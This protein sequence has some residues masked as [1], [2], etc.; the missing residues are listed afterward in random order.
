M[1]HLKKEKIEKKRSG[2]PWYG[3]KLIRFKQTP[4]ENEIL[5]AHDQACVIVQ[6]AINT[7]RKELLIAGSMNAHAK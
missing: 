2:H 3:G 6:E 5:V 1:A 4:T 7:A